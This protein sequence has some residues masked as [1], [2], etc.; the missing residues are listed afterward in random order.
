MPTSQEWIHFAKWSETWG[1]LQ[2]QSLNTDV[3]TDRIVGDLTSATVAG[4]TIVN[5]HTF[6]K[7]AELLEDKSSI[8]SDRPILPMFGELIGWKASVSI[9]RYGPTHRESRKMIHQELG[10]EPS[11]QRFYS[12]QNV[13]SFKFLQELL[14]SPRSFYKATDQYVCTLTVIQR[15]DVH[16]TEHAVTSRA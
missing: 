6:A 7:A 12:Y 8:Y 3:D 10:T 1:K 11:I 15:T 13:M 14:K 5:I 4:A 2:F 16:V 9:M